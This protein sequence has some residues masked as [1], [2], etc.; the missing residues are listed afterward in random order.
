MALSG[1]VVLHLRIDNMTTRTHFLVASNLAVNAIL[2]TELIDRHVRGILPKERRIAFRNG[3]SVTLLGSAPGPEGN[4]K[5]TENLPTRTR[6]NKVRVAKQIVLPPISQ[7]P[8][9]INTETRD[10]VFLRCHPKTVKKNLSL[11]ANG[12]ME[13][14][15]LLFWVRMSN[16]RARTVRIPKGAVIGLTL[17]APRAVLTITYQQARELGLDPSGGPPSPGRDEEKI[18]MSDLVDRTTGRSR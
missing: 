10:V 13:P 12:V 17:P 2:G 11:M 4:R 18:T 3:G 1:V 5:I 15:E 16:S 14:T 8:G 7:V 6:T 9:L